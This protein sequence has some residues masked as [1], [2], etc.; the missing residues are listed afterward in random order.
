[1]G[2]GCQANYAGEEKEEEEGTWGGWPGL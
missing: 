2:D 1:M